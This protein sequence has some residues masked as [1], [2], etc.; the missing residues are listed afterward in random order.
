MFTKKLLSVVSTLFIGSQLLSLV[1]G[2]ALTPCSDETL[3]LTNSGALS[4][5]TTGCT[6]GGTS[7]CL[8][9][10]SIYGYTSGEGNTATC[11]IDNEGTYVLLGDAKLNGETIDASNKDTLKIY[12]CTGVSDVKCL[13]TFG[14]VLSSGNQ[15][16][17]IN[18]S[19]TN[20][21]VAKE[22]IATVESLSGGNCNDGVLYNDSGNIQLCLGGKVYSQKIDE[23]SIIKSYVLN[24]VEGNIFT[25][26]DS[27]D[28]NK[29][30]PMVVNVGDN[31]II[32]S[33]NAYD[34]C[35]GSNSEVSE[36]FKEFCT[37]AN[38]PC[39]DS[40][41]ECESTGICKK[42]QRDTSCKIKDDGTAN[43]SCNT[44]GYYIINTTDSADGDGFR[45]L[46]L[47]S[48]GDSKVGTLINCSTANTCTP[49]PGTGFQKGYYK[50]AAST[51]E[52]DAP[53]IKCTANNDCTIITA[54][55]SDCTNVGDI[56][57][58]SVFKICLDKGVAV[59][60]VDINT[61]STSQSH[62]VSLDNAS[63][64]G[65]VNAGKYV[66]VEAA[67]GNVL[68]STPGKVDIAKAYYYT[69]TTYKI[70]AKAEKSGVC[71]ASKTIIEFKFDKSGS[72]DDTLIVYDKHAEHTFP[73][74]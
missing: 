7:Y 52:N 37:S 15:Y 42:E 45:S 44:S 22:A 58:A 14:Y 16:L 5:V 34:Y 26:A 57:F 8:S 39:T 71:T 2:T 10:T 19:G 62:F 30:K 36:T 50:N 43:G 47:K 66:K 20:A 65:D 49:V 29:N 6:F 12:Q 53:Y 27:D 55:S 46:V 32:L 59:T 1:S 41:Y 70:H 21:F 23:T 25:N 69:D 17:T 72:T 9:G 51:G 18:A 61:T 68:L 60:P 54:V 40:P 63:I 11:V 4:S 24:N 3:A 31:K 56:T 13:Q 67:N 35:A 48:D 28:A 33:T 73:S 38:D 74:A 64:F